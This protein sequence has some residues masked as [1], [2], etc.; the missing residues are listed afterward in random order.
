MEGR[1]GLPMRVGVFILAAPIMLIA[2]LV[3]VGSLIQQG[4]SPSA[5]LDGGFGV[6][7]KAILHHGLVCVSKEDVVRLMKATEAKDDQGQINLIASGAVRAPELQ[8]ELLILT[9][10]DYDGFPLRQVRVLTGR[11]S[12]ISGWVNTSQLSLSTK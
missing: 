8:A 4:N 7:S 3:V 2:V 6:G 9:A 5:S 10:T 1:S 11:Y 12:G